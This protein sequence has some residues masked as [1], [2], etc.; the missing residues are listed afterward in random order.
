MLN[1]IVIGCPDGPSARTGSGSV[2]NIGI[3]T[4]T[5][6]NAKLHRG[7]SRIPRNIFLPGLL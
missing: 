4:A 7:F 2:N 6:D 5:A 3:A 1:P